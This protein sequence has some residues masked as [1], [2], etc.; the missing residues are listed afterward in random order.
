M[1]QTQ[2]LANN[3]EGKQPICV[4]RCKKNHVYVFYGYVNVSMCQS[5]FAQLCQSIFAIQEQI[6]EGLISTSHIS[7]NYASTTLVIPIDDFCILSQCLTNAQERLGVYEDCPLSDI[8]SSQEEWG[9]LEEIVIPSITQKHYV[10]QH[11]HL[12]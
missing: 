6:D 12:N 5:C 8:E 3:K 2:I 10:P 9:N 11:T 7:V 4:Y 1:N